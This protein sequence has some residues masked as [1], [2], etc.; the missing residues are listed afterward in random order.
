MALETLPRDIILHWAKF[1]DPS[2][3][4]SLAKTSKALQ[5]LVDHDRVW[6]WVATCKFGMVGLEDVRIK[7]HFEKTTWK[8]VCVV[9][10]KAH[11]STDFNN[12][13]DCAGVCWP[14]LLRRPDRCM[15]I[16]HGIT[17]INFR[18]GDIVI[19]NKCI[20]E[21]SYSEWIYVKTIEIWNGRDFMTAEFGVLQEFC[22]P[23]FLVD[24]F[25]HATEVVINFK[26]PEEQAAE[27][28]L[29]KSLNI[30]GYGVIDLSD[31]VDNHPDSHESF[32]VAWPDLEFTVVSY[33]PATGE[34]EL[35]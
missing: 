21:S 19:S 5:S 30:S 14:I 35:S 4:G 2:D 33:R 1:L 10:W 27:C 16:P 12:F 24:Y 23:E 20:L 26:I 9:F 15:L 28:R 7:G 13:V 3:F 8:D 11:A 25:F 31:P 22:Y 6:K 17:G 32:W 29:T 18:R 34:V